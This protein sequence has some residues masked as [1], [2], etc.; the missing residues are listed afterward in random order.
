MDTVLGWPALISLINSHV[1]DADSVADAQAAMHVVM[2]ATTQSML[3][4]RIG[5]MMRHSLRSNISTAISGTVQFQINCD[6]VSRSN[7]S[8]SPV[9]VQAQ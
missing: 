6:L 7:D 8:G 3:T 4:N 2:T 5:F 1:T 9:R